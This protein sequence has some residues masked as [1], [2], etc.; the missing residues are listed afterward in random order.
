MV[1]PNDLKVRAALHASILIP[2]VKAFKGKHKA[3]EISLPRYSLFF[4][5][6]LTEV[7]R[8]GRRGRV[9]SCFA[10]EYNKQ[11][12]TNTALKRDTRVYYLQV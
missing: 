4:F 3:C 7:Y 12:Q 11:Y 5:K 10:E 9:N 6:S 1:T 8:T 2:G